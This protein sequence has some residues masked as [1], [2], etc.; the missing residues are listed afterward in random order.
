MPGQEPFALV[1]RN[2][3]CHLPREEARELRPLPLNRLDETRVRERDRGLVG[4]RLHERGVIVRKRPW[5]ATHDDD[6]PDEL[7][8][9]HDRHPE[10][11]PKESWPK[12]GV[13]RIGEHVRN[14]DRPSLKGCTPSG[15]R[16]VQGMRMRDVVLSGRLL[17]LVCTHVE[18][19]VLEEPEGPVIGLAE[20]P[21]R[22]GHLLE[23]RLDSDR[24]GDGAKHTADRALLLPQILEL[25]G[26]AH[27]ASCDA[28]HLEKLK[29]NASLLP[30]RWFDSRVRLALRAG[31]AAVELLAW[32]DRRP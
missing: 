15:R 9:E 17:A 14:V 19:P 32:P 12:I 11:R 26:E 6:N 27:R 20:P 5:L 7:V 1:A 8:L 25:T 31:V 23:H 13:F 22:L 29:L 4:K 2:Q 24:A 18:E 28:S 3:V 30:E 21:A 16:P 10:H